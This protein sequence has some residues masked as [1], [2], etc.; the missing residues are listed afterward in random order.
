MALTHDP[1]TDTYTINSVDANQDEIEVTIKPGHSSSSRRKTF[2]KKVFPDSGASICLGGTQHLEEFDMLPQELIPCN[3]TI[4]VVGGGTLPCLGYINVEFTVNGTTT[5]QRL[6]ICEKIDRIFFSKDACIETFILPSTFPQPLPALKFMQ[7]KDNVYPLNQHATPFQPRTKP[8]TAVMSVHFQKSAVPKRV[9]GEGNRRAPPSRPKQIPHPPVESSIPLLRKY[10]VDNFRDSALDRSP[11]FPKMK[12]TKGHIHLQPNAIPFAVH[13]PIP[14]PH[15]EKTIVK[16]MLDQYVERGIITPV[17]IGTPVEWCALMVLGRKKDGSPRITVDFQHLNKQCF[18]ETHHTEPP[19]HL[20]S[21][22][23]P[24]TKKTVLDATDSYHSVELDEESQLLTMFITEWGRYMYLRVPQGFFAAGDIFTSRY[25]NI[26]K[27]ISNKVK[28]VDD[29]L[30]H[31]TD[32]EQSFWDTWDFLT[33]CAENGVTINEEKL[34]FCLDEVEF[35][36]LTISNEG[37]TPAKSILAAISDFPLPTDLTS[38]RSWFGLVNQVSWAYSISPIMEPFRDLIKPNHVF[39]WDE[40]LTKLFETSKQEILSKISDGVRSFELGRRTAIQ[41][42]WCKHGI[43]YLLLQKHCVCANKDNVRCCPDGWKLIYA[44]SR[45]TKDAET[46]YKPT[47]G[48]AL[49]IAWGL[50]HSRMFTLGCTD[51]LVSTDHKPLL[52]IFNDRDLNS[53]KNPRIQDF[54]EATLAWRFNIA[55]NPGKW[56]KGPDAVSRQ[57]SPLLAV[58]LASKP[59]KQTLPSDELDEPGEERILSAGLSNLFSASNSAISLDDIRSEGGKDQLYSTLIRAIQEGFPSSRSK[60]EPQLREFWEVRERLFTQDNIVYMDQRVV[61]PAKLRKLILESLHSANQGVSGMRRRA[62]ATVYWPGMSTSISNYR[63][64]CQDCQQNAPSQP[65]EPIIMSPPP[66]WPFQQVCMDYFFVGEHAYLV[67]VDRYS[68]WPSVF[69]FRPGQTTATHLLAVL[70]NH[71]ATFGIPEESSSDGGPQFESQ[72][73]RTFL[74]T[75]GIHF[76]LSSVGYAQSNGR[77]EVGVKT[78]KRLIHNNISPDGSLNNDKILTALLEYRNT[79][80]PDTKLSPAQILFH[81]QL[82]DGIPTHREQYRLHKKWIIAAD[83]R[84]RLFAKKNRAIEQYYNKHTRSLS[85]LSVGTPVLIQGKNKKWTKQGI[86]V[87]ALKY[88]QYRV[89]VSGS[90]RSTLQ[91]RRFLRPFYTTKSAAP[92]QLTT[93][94]HLHPTAT[95]PKPG[96]I[97]ELSMSNNLV[98]Q[99][100]SI[101]THTHEQPDLHPTDNTQEVSSQPPEERDRSDSQNIPHQ[102]IPQRVPRSLRNLATY[103]KPGLREQPMQPEGRR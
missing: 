50:E 39:Y 85:E 94:T 49:A 25:D 92:Q 88:R 65:A 23:P 36:G 27:D 35:A 22:V 7:Q 57:P 37:I 73:F 76:R 90:G 28:I 46:R 34:Q 20:A 2:N 77:A 62:N 63:V 99:P 98:T 15:H 14:I 19:F 96:T 86:I 18:R 58:T 79:P 13:S 29:A 31:S 51:L 17:P 84:E 30:L 45:F 93:P 26:T 95:L 91:N 87:E 68:G 21:R 3:K 52:G 67:I 83:E 55:H 82:R 69:H 33:L 101:P 12:T 72:A 1:V 78:M 89:K 4:S 48:E 53:I 97:V 103:N 54:K 66:E 74:R 43:G 24:N 38:A 44:G 6:Y 5:K 47:E 60:T 40:T 81:R 41:T 102:R 10:I 42:D 75:W 61:I 16:T 100:T 8:P 9:L 59:T 71:F 32:I 80:L 70:R 64:N 11:P 56:H